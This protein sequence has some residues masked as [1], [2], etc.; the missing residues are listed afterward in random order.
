MGRRDAL[1]HI[2]HYPDLPQR[3]ALAVS[4]MGAQAPVR[5][6]SS[7]AGRA[8]RVHPAKKGPGTL[9]IPS[10][11]GQGPVNPCARSVL[12]RRRRALNQWWTA[13]RPLGPP[14]C[15]WPQWPPWAPW[16]REALSTAESGLGLRLKPS[17][18]MPC[19]LEVLVIIH[20]P[21][22]P[23]GTGLL[24]RWATEAKLSTA[25]HAQLAASPIARMTADRI[26]ALQ[27]TQRL[28]RSALPAAAELESEF[29]AAT[30]PFHCS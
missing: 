4:W 16:V 26:T 1:R 8:P 9:A 21:P 18:L 6:G 15:S 30:P 14:A 13:L 23:A 12:K 11:L 3:H 29:I 28:P 27:Y 19:V 24:G 5:A 17:T 10:H 22:R 20:G 7:G 2:R 25:R